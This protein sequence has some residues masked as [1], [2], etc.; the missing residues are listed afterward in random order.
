M[1]DK[2]HQTTIVLILVIF[3]ATELWEVH[4]S[5]QQRMHQT[6]FS[7]VKPLAIFN[8]LCLQQII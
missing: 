4:A 8:I 6:C 2:R 3:K 1:R 5:L 7:F